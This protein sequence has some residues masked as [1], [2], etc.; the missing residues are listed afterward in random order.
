MALTYSLDTHHNH[1]HLTA[2]G[3]LTLAEWQESLARAIEDPAAPPCAPILIDFAAEAHPP[4]D[5][6]LPLLAFLLRRIVEHR[7]CRLALHSAEPEH[8]VA[9]AMLA[10]SCDA[11]SWIEVFHTLTHARA[12]LTRP[13][14]NATA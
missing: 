13:E 1:L 2:S 9:L 10:F 8:G 3:M 11:P 5:W 7:R 6:E 12:W 14:K 4:R